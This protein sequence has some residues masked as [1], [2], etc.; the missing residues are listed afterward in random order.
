MMARPA[1][2]AMFGRPGL[3]SRTGLRHSNSQSFASLRRRKGGR[4]FPCGEPLVRQVCLLPPKLSRA[5]AALSLELQYSPGAV[6]FTGSHLP[7]I[8]ECRDR[9]RG[10]AVHFSFASNGGVAS[11]VVRHA[12]MRRPT[13][14]QR[15]QRSIDL[16]RSNARPRQ[17]SHDARGH[18]ASELEAVI[19]A[20]HCARPQLAAVAVTS[21]Q[22]PASASARLARGLVFVGTEHRE[23]PWTLDDP[24]GTIR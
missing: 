12:E 2:G 22:T 17:P 16:S 1:L 5:N 8:G 14:A 24:T 3:R 11:G 13:R 23:A 4:A 7:V 21:W 15:G 18:I 9:L 6:A 20:A 10:L 19:V